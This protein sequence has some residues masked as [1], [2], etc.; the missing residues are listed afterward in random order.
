MKPTKPSEMLKDSKVL[1]KKNKLKYIKRMN[2]LK[3]FKL[4]YK[5]G[6]KN[7]SKDENPYKLTPQILDL[8]RKRTYWEMGWDEG[9]YLSSGRKKQVQ[10]MQEKPK[11]SH[12]KRTEKHKH[13]KDKN[14]HRRKHKHS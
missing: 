8:I 3:Y 1:A 6:K 9:Y 14:K 13:H 5:A 12:G 2:K 11:E 4:G 7:K 10:L